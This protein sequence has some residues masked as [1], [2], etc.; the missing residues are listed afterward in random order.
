MVQPSHLEYVLRASRFSTH[1]TMLFIP[2]KNALAGH[3]A[4]S[5][6]SMLGPVKG[7]RERK[8]FRLAKNLAVYVDGVDGFLSI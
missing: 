6:P 8:S 5:D 1:H 4:K 7:G 3:L 2:L